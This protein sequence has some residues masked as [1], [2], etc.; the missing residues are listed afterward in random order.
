MS[1]VPSQRTG[2]IE[3]TAPPESRGLQ[4]D[5]I[6]LLV[7]DRAARS[8]KH[9][10]FREFADFLRSGDLLVVNDS[11]T[12]PAAIPAQ[13]SNGSPIDLHVSTKID[14]RIWIAEPRGTVVCGEELRLPNG[15]SAVTIAPIDPE[16][17][18]LWYTWFQLP[19]PM[20]E[21]LA[22][23]GAP[24]R[25]SYVKQRFPL[26]DYQTI[27]A[28]EAGSSEMPS[29]G[30]PFSPR[31]LGTLHSKGV[32]IAPITLHCGVA[33]FE[34]P[35]RPGMERFM[36]SSSTAACVNATRMHGGRVIAIGTTA[37][38]AL[39]SAIDGDDVI[40]ASGWTDL[41]IDE[42]HRVRAADGMLTGF[43]D[44]NATHIWILR[45]FLDRELLDAAYDEAASEQYRY[46][47]FGDV[48]LIL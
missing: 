1:A 5:E 38:R 40:A 43:H 29:A 11:A 45:A 32:E 24:I 44:G 35:E 21:Y 46:H 30:R 17:P 18:R 19:Q 41:V 26:S 6:R 34:A 2:L 33:S 4:R 31:V 28:R 37:L 8:H 14:Q 16:Q 10:A 12:V 42:V 15:G 25:Y 3:A 27:F 47:E 36:V 22:T 23:V 7:T 48:H 20:F 39:E 13:R 9:A